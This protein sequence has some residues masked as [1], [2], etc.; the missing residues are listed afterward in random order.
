[1]HHPCGGHGQSVGVF[2]YIG[3]FNR[4]TPAQEL[5]ISDLVGLVD[6]QDSAKTSL[7]KGAELSVDA[8]RHFPVL[9]GLNGGLDPDRIKQTEFD[10]DRDGWGGIDLVHPP[11]YCSLNSFKHGARALWL[12]SELY[13]YKYNLN[14][15][16]HT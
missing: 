7:L 3:K 6:F 5:L 9:A 11:K 13:K 15:V 1:M 8:S 12:G 4:A 14:N 2:D 16:S 10:L